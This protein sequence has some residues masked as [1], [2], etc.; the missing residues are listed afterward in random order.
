MNILFF[1]HTSFAAKGLKNLFKKKGGIIYFSRKQKEKKFFFDL[2]KKNNKISYKNKIKKKSIILFFSSTV[3]KKENVPNWNYISKINIDGVINFLKNLELKP[4]KI[5]LISSCAVYGKEKENLSETDWLKPTTPYAIT[6]LA[7]ENIFRIYCK[8]NNIKLFILRL[9]YVYGDEMPDLRLLKRLKNTFRA[10]KKINI[11][12]KNLNLNLIHTE[13]I[14]N[15]VLKSLNKNEGLINAV[16]KKKITIKNFVES[17][18]KK[19]EPN[20]K[21]LNKNEFFS[22]EFKNYF[23]NFKFMKITDAIKNL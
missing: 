13:D 9:G 8:I 21:Q 18:V 14:K 22:K 3:P 5:I 1:G 6:K 11:Y 7:Q 17:L 10:E 16:H 12:N 2:K 4:K 20:S 19:K 15:I 23:P